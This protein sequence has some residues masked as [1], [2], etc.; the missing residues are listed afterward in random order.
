MPSRAGD[1]HQHWKQMLLPHREQQVGIARCAKQSD[2]SKTNVALSCCCPRQGPAPSQPLPSLPVSQL[3][4]AQLWGEV[5]QLADPMENSS[6]LCHFLP[7]FHGWVNFL[8]VQ[9][10][11]LTFP[12][13]TLLQHPTCE[14]S[15]STGLGVGMAVAVPQRGS[16]ISVCAGQGSRKSKDLCLL[17]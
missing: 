17:T 9:A 6:F 15:G 7:P 2:S 8:L 4:M 14:S 12:A 3:L 10:G 13:T 1:V 16:A 11:E 5:I